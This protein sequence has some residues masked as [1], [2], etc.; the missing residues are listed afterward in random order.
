MVWT[1]L[2][3]TMAATS[4]GMTKSNAATKPAPEASNL[5][6]TAPI[7][8]Y[9][10]HLDSHPQTLRSMDDIVQQLLELSKKADE[11]SER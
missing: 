5:I 4:A 11:N 1:I 2:A 8:H 7:L 9:P 6:S 10:A 3:T